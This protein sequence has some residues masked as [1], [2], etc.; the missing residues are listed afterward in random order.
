MAGLQVQRDDAEVEAPAG[1]K[2][3]VKEL[4][5]SGV[6]LI[7]TKRFGDSRGYF[8]ETYSRRD[9]AAAEIGHDFVQ[10]N[11]SFSAPKGTIRGMHVQTPPYAQ[12]KLVR[13]LQGR[14]LDVVV[15]IRRSSPSY[16]RHVA[17]ELSADAGEQL[18][19]P[20]GFAHGFCTL[21]PDCVVFY[22]VDNVYSAEHDRGI[23]WSDPELGIDWPVPE[24]AAILSDKDRVLPRMRDIPTYFD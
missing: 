13:V 6:K 5:I 1:M 11:E 24:I 22:K 9:F 19:V 16:G 20:V 12:T 14:I 18:L 21:V 2:V 3:E 15:D 17:V 4:A 10:D 23:R 8:A 7:G